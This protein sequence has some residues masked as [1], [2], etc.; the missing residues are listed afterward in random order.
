MPQVKLSD[1]AREDPRRLYGFL[2]EKDAG[3]AGRAIEAIAIAAK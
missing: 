3:V 1:R 2:A